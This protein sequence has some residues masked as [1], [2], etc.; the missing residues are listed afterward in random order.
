[1]KQ[2]FFPRKPA[3]VAT[4]PRRETSRPEKLPFESIAFAVAIWLGILVA[5]QLLARL[6]DLP[7]PQ[8]TNAMSAVAV[9]T[10]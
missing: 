4:R 1:M 9:P 10:Y 5:G 8:A 6:T 2:I 3:R 7:R